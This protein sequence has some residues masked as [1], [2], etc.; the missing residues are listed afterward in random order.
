VVALA[1]ALALDKP[2]IYG[3]SDGGQVALE[4][5][6]RYP[7]LTQ[8]L[9]VGGA[10]LELTEGSIRWV[11]SILGDRDSPDIDFEQFEHD[12][13][14]FAADLKEEHGADRWKQLLK[15]IKPMW[16]ATLNYTA[17][18]FARITAPTLLLVGDRDEFIPV[19]D[20]VTSYRTLPNTELAVIPGADHPGLLFSSTKIALALPIILD[21]LLRQSGS[22]GRTIPS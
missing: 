14:Q 10:Y 17:D 1:Q 4:I 13:P 8:A 21:F 7:D 15:Q 16:N 11:R 22:A 5:G 2:L 3:Y 9:V 12:Q 6:M 19:E 18:D 20:A